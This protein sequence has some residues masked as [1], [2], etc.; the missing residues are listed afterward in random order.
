[1]HNIPALH[2]H[3]AVGHVRGGSLYSQKT[4]VAPCWVKASGQMCPATQQHTLKG[5]RGSLR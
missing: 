5:G 2:K 4:V 3:E 1:M